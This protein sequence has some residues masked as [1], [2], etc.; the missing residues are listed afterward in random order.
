MGA[1]T[2][3][4]QAAKPKTLFSN[5]HVFDGVHEKRIENAY[6]LVEGNL[7]KQISAQ[8]ITA[9][10]AMVI[11][12]GGRTLMPGLIDTHSHLNQGGLTVPQLLTGNVY[13]IGIAQGKFAT[14][15]LLR[16]VTTVRDPGGDS[17]GLKRA[18]DEGLIPGPRVESAG[19]IIGQTNGH[20]DNRLPYT[21]HPRFDWVGLTP[22]RRL[23]F[24]YMVRQRSW[25]RCARFCGRERASSK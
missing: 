14:E 24:S 4:D 12:G 5:V 13:Y 11:D 19:P 10:G 23:N 22:D 9:D 8:K 21:G 6:V 15:T 18:I 20:G 25:R 7:I 1:T 17:L 2:P 16:G 3:A